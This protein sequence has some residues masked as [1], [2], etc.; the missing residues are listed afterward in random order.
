MRTTSQKWRATEVVKQSIAATGMASFPSRGGLTMPLVARL[1]L[2]AW[3]IFPL[4]PES[5]PSDAE[6]AN[7][8]NSSHVHM[9]TSGAAA[10]AGCQSSGSHSGYEFDECAV[11]ACRFYN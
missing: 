8:H 1:P 11:W 4:A 9:C 2:F 7:G 10:E 5:K 3:I 6:S